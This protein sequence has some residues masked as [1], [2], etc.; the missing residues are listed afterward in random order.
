MSGSLK[1]PP[2]HHAPARCESSSVYS[3]P[4]GLGS[5]AVAEPYWKGRMMR[6]VSWNVNWRSDVALDQGRLLA[7]LHCDIV[8]LQEVNRKSAEALGNAAGLAWMIVSEPPEDST[9]PRRQRL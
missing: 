3:S 5:S 6:V 7:E 2:S 1:V 4:P 8:I 9:E